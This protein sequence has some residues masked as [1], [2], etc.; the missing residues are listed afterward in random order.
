VAAVSY[1][2]LFTQLFNCQIIGFSGFSYAGDKIYVSPGF[3]RNGYPLIRSMVDQAEMRVD[4][5]YVGI[6]STPT[7]IICG[8]QAEYRK[9]C[10]ATEGAGCSLGTPWGQSFVVLNPDGFNTDVISHE[11]S[12][13]ELLNRLGWWKVTFEIPHWFNEGVALMLD[14]RFVGNTDPIRRYLDYHDEWLYYTGGGQMILELHEIATISTFFR[15]GPRQIM[16]AYMTS[17]TE[18]SYWLAAMRADGF[19]AFLNLMVSGQSFFEA[20]QSAENQSKSDKRYFL[21]ANPLRLGMGYE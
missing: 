1:Y 3:N 17:A 7:F 6:Q 8:T 4:S 12:H 10:N 13:V 21:P 16:L 2:F 14:R 15:G 11:L 19:D 9:Y 18:V 20:Y 5:F